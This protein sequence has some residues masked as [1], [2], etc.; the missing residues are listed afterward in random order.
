[1]KTTLITLAALL[2]ALTFAKADAYYV[3]VSKV[4]SS[5]CK[6]TTTRTLSSTDSFTFT[7]QLQTPAVTY[8]TQ[9][10]A[11]RGV[12]WGS[13]N[14]GATTYTGTTGGDTGGGGGGNKNHGDQLTLNVDFVNS[15]N[16]QITHYSFNNPYVYGTIVFTGSSSTGCWSMSTY[17]G[18]VSQTVSPGTN[19]LPPSAPI[20]LYWKPKAK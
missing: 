13:L 10:G 15:D 2:A 3:T 11:H 9:C 1:M 8:V 16:A 6:I 19:T 20:V 14:E 17:G 5:Y 4:D 7:S 18:N 12:P